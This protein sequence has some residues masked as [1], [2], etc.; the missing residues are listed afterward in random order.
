[1]NYK[2]LFVLNSIVFIT[3]VTSKRRKIFYQRIL[4]DYNLS[5]SQ[6]QKGEKDIWQG[7]Y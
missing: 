2:R 4:I 7:R 5:E 6:I 3:F 1:M